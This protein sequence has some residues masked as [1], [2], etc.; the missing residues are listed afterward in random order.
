M[1]IP[2]SLRTVGVGTVGVLAMGLLWCGCPAVTLTDQVAAG[3][4]FPYAQVAGR[5]ADELRLCETLAGAGGKVEEYVKE[6]LLEGNNWP[7]S[8]WRFGLLLE[9]ERL[10][11]GLQCSPL[12]LLF[13]TNGRD[14]YVVA[15][16][17]MRLAQQG[18]LHGLRTMEARAAAHE[19]EEELWASQLVASSLELCAVGSLEV[20]MNDASRTCVSS[21]LRE[22]FSGWSEESDCGMRSDPC[23]AVPFE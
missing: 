21:I 23:A 9:Q 11:E 16:A 13:V 5:R 6:Q 2:L 19:I 8:N 3:E 20:A 7:L 12:Y 1:A 14:G 10:G 22:S 4:R 17:A 15:W 18:D